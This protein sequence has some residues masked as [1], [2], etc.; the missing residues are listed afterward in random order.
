MTRDAFK[1][2][3]AEAVEAVTVAAETR[4]GRTLPRCYALAWLGGPGIDPGDDV[5][6]LLAQKVF[7][8]EN[9]IF[10]CVD[11][12][13]D[14]LQADGRLLL[15]CYR[16]GYPPGPYGEHWQYA[17]GG[18]D[19]GRVGPFKLGCSNLVEKPSVQRP[20]VCPNRNP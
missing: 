10:P 1:K 16:A 7:V 5:V 6:E 18:H 8:S 4:V 11:L 9:E 2:I 12:F 13:L 17:T 19:S 3:I 15:V 20:A 14:S